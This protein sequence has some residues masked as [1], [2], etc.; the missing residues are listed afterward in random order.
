MTEILQGGKRDLSSQANA[1]IV[2]TL[3]P[4]RTLACSTDAVNAVADVLGTL[5]KDL[6]AA[7]VISGTITEH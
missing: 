1:Y 5:I 7:G 6:I 3:T 2:T 4:D